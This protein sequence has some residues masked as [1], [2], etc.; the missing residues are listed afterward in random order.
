VVVR[1]E[2]PIDPA[3]GWVI[4]FGDLKNAFEP[5]RK[6]LDH[7]YLNEIE[8]LDNPTSEAVALWIWERIVPG[9]PG[10]TAVTIQET[11]TSGCTYRGRS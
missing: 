3:T 5:V 8:G 4:D 2:G 6:Q 7:T 11:C 1:V 10:L 9:L